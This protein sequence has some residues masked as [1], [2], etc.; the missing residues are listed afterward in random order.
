MTTAPRD[1]ETRSASLEVKLLLLCVSSTTLVLAAMGAYSYADQRERLTSALTSAIDGASA[2]L[3]NG[4]PQAVWNVTKDQAFNHLAGEMSVPDIDAILVRGD[5]DI[6]FAGAVRKDGKPAPMDEGWRKPE[7]ALSMT[8]DVTWEGKVIGRGEIVYSLHALESRLD[9]QL[10]SNLIQI[11]LVDLILSGLL[12]FI[13][14]RLVTSPIAGLRR[15]TEEVVRTGDLR[16]QITTRSQDEIGQLAAAFQAM[17]KNLEK[18]TVEAERIAKGDLTV[19][20]AVLSDSDAFGRA[21]RKMASELRDI[22]VQIGQASVQ[23]AGGSQEMSDASQSLSQ[24]ATQQAASLEEISSSITEIGSQAKSNADSA[25]QANTLVAAARDSA[26][27]GDQ[28]MKAMVGAMQEINTASQQIAKIM[29][30]I[31]DIAFQ[32]NLLALNAAVEAARAGK[33]GKGFA[34]VAQEVRNLAGR[35][36]KAARETADMIESSAAKVTSGLAVANATSASFDQI[37]GN[38]VKVADIVGEIAAASREQAEGIGQISQGLAQIDQVAQ[39][40]TANAE[41]TASAAQELASS[42][43]TIRRLLS[44]FQVGAQ[45][46]A[47]QDGQGDPLSAP[48]GNGTASFSDASEPLA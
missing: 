29:K 34:V 10:V 37:V 15:V 27:Q 23:V 3:V 36:A 24:G 39:R 6:L 13:L 48:R 9:S 2:R 47:Q 25:H 17:M 1:R 5:R 42:A 11:V 16:Q 12:L 46:Q 38:V 45:A 33:H 20:V 22:V 32:T 35:S 26:Q 31:D 40:N 44:R 41:E 4:L 19:D 21:F 28:Q 7:R 14:S 30:V 8:F 43:T 18:K